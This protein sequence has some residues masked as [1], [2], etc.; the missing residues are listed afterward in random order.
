MTRCCLKFASKLNLLILNNFILTNL[1]H[2]QT[3]TIFNQNLKQTKFIFNDQYETKHE[4]EMGVKSE[5]DCSTQ[6]CVEL[7]QQKFSEKIASIFEQ[8]LKRQTMGLKCTLTSLSL[9]LSLSHTHT[10]T[11]TSTHELTHSYTHML[12]H[13]TA[14]FEA[15][16]NTFLH[17][18]CFHFPT[19]KPF[20]FYI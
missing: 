6:K 13:E 1:L 12:Y 8:L 17:F 10:Q 3:P 5:D 7:V 20:A 11:R 15:A 14:F 4:I 2:V 19:A 16:K 18:H 9:S